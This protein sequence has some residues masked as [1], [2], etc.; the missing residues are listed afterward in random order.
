MRSLYGAI[1]NS[2]HL[3]F[4]VEILI[5]VYLK[6]ENKIINNSNNKSALSSSSPSFLVLFHILKILSVA[7]CLPSEKQRG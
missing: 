1:A 5:P 6:G 2:V 3:E 4:Y 7:L